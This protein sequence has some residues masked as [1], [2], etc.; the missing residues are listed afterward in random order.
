[1]KRKI[2]N[3]TKYKKN[4]ANYN[5][6]V[7]YLNNTLMQDKKVGGANDATLN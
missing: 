3:V 6:Y 7:I 2:I 1:M 4:I 5:K